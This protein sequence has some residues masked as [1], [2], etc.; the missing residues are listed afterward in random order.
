MTNELAPFAPDDRDDDPV[1]ST[2]MTPK[3]RARSLG[4]ADA[5]KPSE[6]VHLRLIN[7]AEQPYDRP[8]TRADCDNVPRPCPFVGCKHNLYLDYTKETGNIRLNFPDREPYEMPADGSCSLDVAEQGGVTLNAAGEYINLTRERIRQVEN[9]ALQK[10]RAPPAMGRRGS[11]LAENMAI[12]RTYEHHESGSAA[13]PLA[14]EMLET[15][16]DGGGEEEEGDLRRFKADLPH[17]LDG[18]VS[19][20]EYSAALHRIWDHWREDR[21]ALT[22][23][24]LHIVHGRY[25]SARHVKVLDAI[26]DCWRDHGR[27]PSI[28]EIADVAEVNGTTASTRRQNASAI[29]RSL[30]ELGLIEGKR[31]QLRVVIVRMESDAPEEPDPEPATQEPSE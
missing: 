15:S 25:V 28:L 5:A 9:E 2:I 14:E 24:D 1:L 17:I 4:R 26:H 22:R 13:S 6:V 16:S 11:A 10:L 31:G 8:H 3:L 21:H 23:G 27:P 29:L 30:R 19:D 12:L 7:D 18:N 20:E